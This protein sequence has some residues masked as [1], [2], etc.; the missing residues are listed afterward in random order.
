MTSDGKFAG[1]ISSGD[2]FYHDGATLHTLPGLTTGATEVVSDMNESGTIAGYA[3]NADGMTRAVT[4]VRSETP[5]DLGVLPNTHPTPGTQKS[6]ALEINRYGQVVG[7]SELWLDGVGY[8]QTHAFVYQGGVMRDLNDLVEAGTPLL[9]CAYAIND[10][11]QIATEDG[12]LTPHYV[13]D[14]GFDSGVLGDWM[15]ATATGTV[16]FTTDPDDAANA[17]LCLT[18]GSPVAAAQVVD[19]PNQPFVIEFDYR[20]E[21]LDGELTA[22]VDGQDLLPGISPVSTEWMHA[23]RRVDDPALMGLAAIRVFVL[24][25]VTARRPPSG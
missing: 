3:V 14:A 18:T 6:Q 25:L 10:K 2:A 7:W 1:Q 15:Q 5:T 13:A 22:S 8:R 23:E 11:G 21:S 9:T 20:F 24:R 4:W 16:S 12:L 17:V 19:T